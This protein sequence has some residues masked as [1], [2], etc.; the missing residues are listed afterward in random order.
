MVPRR[1]HWTHYSPQPLSS[2]PRCSLMSYRLFAVAFL[3]AVL[4]GCFDQPGASQSYLPP[5]PAPS[6]APSFSVNRVHKRVHNAAVP[7]YVYVTDRGNGQL[8]V[9]PYGVSNPAPIRSIP[10]DSPLG[11]AVDPTGSVYVAQ[12]AESQISVFN[13]GATAQTGTIT[14]DVD[15]PT[16][17]TADSSGN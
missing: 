12:W 13:D 14:A 2:P 11:V 9:Y 15:R 1:C 16:S 8:L 5:A 10:L 3:A 17:I 4:S 7:R 6:T